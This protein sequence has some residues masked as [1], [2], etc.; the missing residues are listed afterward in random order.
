MPACGGGEVSTGPPPWASLPF[1][2]ARAFRDRHDDQSNANRSENNRATGV[3]QPSYPVARAWPISNLCKGG[4][5]A[6]A[7]GG[8]RLDRACRPA[9]VSPQ[10]NERHFRLIQETNTRPR[11]QKTAPPKIGHSR[12]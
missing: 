3:D 12:P 4:P 9:P 10:G 5:A 11:P 8:Y 2:S 6:P 1:S 7:F